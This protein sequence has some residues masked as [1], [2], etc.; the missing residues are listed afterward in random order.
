MLIEKRD[1]YQFRNDPQRYM[2][3]LVYICVCVCIHLTS[4]K[5]CTIESMS[6]KR[7]R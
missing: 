6:R 5:Y 2:K 3:A 4:I 7:E 1:K